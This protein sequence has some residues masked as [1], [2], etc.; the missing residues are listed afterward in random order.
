MPMH[1]YM[2]DYGG[3]TQ[4]YHSALEMNCSKCFGEVQRTDTT[5]QQWP[6]ILVCFMLGKRHQEIIQS[7]FYFPL[8]SDEPYCFLK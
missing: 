5:P 6:S 1:L 2:S 4:C 3:Q 8:A 7:H